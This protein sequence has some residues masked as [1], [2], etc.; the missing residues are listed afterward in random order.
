MEAMLSCIDKGCFSYPLRVQKMYIAYDSMA[1]NSLMIKRIK[2]SESVKNEYVHK[3]ANRLVHDVSRLGE[4]QLDIRLD[5]FVLSH[6]RKADEK[7]GRVDRGTVGMPHEM[8]FFNIL[9]RRLLG[10]EPFPI[11][12]SRQ[13]RLPE[14]VSLRGI[15]EDS[16]L[17]EHHGFGYLKEVQRLDQEKRDLASRVQA[18]SQAR[19]PQITGLHSSFPELPH[20]CNAPLCSCAQAHSASAQV[21]PH[22]EQP[23]VEQSGHQQPVVKASRKSAKSRQPDLLNARELA[24]VKPDE[25]ELMLKCVSEAETMKKQVKKLGVYQVCII[26]VLARARARVRGCIIHVLA[27]VRARVRGRG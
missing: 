12:A 6:N 9:C 26:H 7:L 10:L 27:R 19:S 8:A 14:S 24:P 18:R 5:F 11:L 4:D 13:Q 16:P 1:T 22:Q 2:K 25:I 20:P 3:G 15:E 17:F 21:V 23:H